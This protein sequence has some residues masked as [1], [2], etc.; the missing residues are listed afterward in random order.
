MEGLP[1]KN[2]EKRYL[3]H[4]VPDDMK[5]N[6]IYPLNELK[7]IHPDLYLSK[8]IKYKG[9]EDVMDN[10]IK[11]LEAKWNDVIFM[12]A[13]DPKELKEELIKAGMKPKE[14]K[15]FQI[16][17]TKLDLQKTKVF[18]FKENNRKIFDDEFTDFKLEDLEKYS[19]IPEKSKNYFKESFAKNGNA[20]M[21][22]F[23]PHILHKGSIDISDFPVI[24][25]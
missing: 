10:L 7:N 12:S 1:K 6:I 3:Y 9:R 18:L 14:F 16:D 19:I 2:T 21:F 13:V 4:R 25:V 8:A 20:L 5:G 15:F 22:A 24:T 23:I 17:P 11:S